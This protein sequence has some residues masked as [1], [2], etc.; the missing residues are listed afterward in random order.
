MSNLRSIVESGM[1]SVALEF[2]G[3]VIERLYSL[4]CLSV[5]VERAVGHMLLMY[6]DVSCKSSREVHS[7]M[8]VMKDACVALEKGVTSG[9]KEDTQEVS[10][11]K[12]AS[13]A[14]KADSVAKKAA[15][16][17]A[18][19]GKKGAADD[20]IA[21]LVSEAY[22]AMTSE[23]CLSKKVGSQETSMGETSV[24]ETSVAK[25][26]AAKEASVA[27]KAAAKE[28]AL[29]KKADALAKKAAVKEAA[30]AKKAV[31][32][33]KKAAVKEAALAKKADGIAKKALAKENA[34]KAK[35]LAKTAK[36]ENVVMPVLEEEEIDSS[37]DEI[38]IIDDEIDIIDDE[39]FSIDKDKTMVVG[40]T[41]YY[42][43]EQDGQTIIFSMTNPP[44]PVGLYDAETDTVQEAEFE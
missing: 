24:G 21:Q 20:Q 4:G 18:S 43:G 22:D 9:T 28:V 19:V 15:A 3:D 34:S 16:K 41:E 12:E 14:K 33:A 38:D 25:K 17:E 27:K 37:D 40:G 26:A 2:G 30:L 31:A 6:E 32:L 8:W 35:L 36:I 5:S 1:R 39:G 11:A 10:V 23:G 13:V 44:E 42:Y 29:A 7:K